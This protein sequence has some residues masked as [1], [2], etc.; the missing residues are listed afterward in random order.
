MS[1]TDHLSRGVVPTVV[2]RDLETLR[3]KRL[4]PALS[5]SATKE[6]RK[7]DIEDLDHIQKTLPLYLLM[8]NVRTCRTH[9]KAKA[10]NFTTFTSDLIPMSGNS[11]LEDYVYLLC[12]LYRYM[13]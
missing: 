11:N 13:V 9:W 5:R 6:I 1:R 3:M 12:V 7:V 10:E 8:F 4:W 2:C